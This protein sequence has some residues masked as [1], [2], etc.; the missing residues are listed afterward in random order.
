MRVLL[1][2]LNDAEKNEIVDFSS[3]LL[4]IGDGHLGVDD[5]GDPD[6]K[7][8]EIPEKYLIP[9]HE[10]ALKDLVQFIYDYDLLHNPSASMFCDKAIV[11]PKN[12]T[13]D[14]INKLK[15]HSLPGNPTVYLSVD[16]IIPHANERGYTEVCLST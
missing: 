4:Q 11:C 2:N 9:D 1:P 5:E 15:F 16:L 3:W 14:E 8:V 7:W 12:E 13:A 10:D 6:T